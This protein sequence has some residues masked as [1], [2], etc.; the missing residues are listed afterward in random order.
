MYRDSLSENETLKAS[1]QSLEKS[2]AQKKRSFQALKPV[3]LARLSSM[4]GQISN[5]SH[6]VLNLKDEVKMG[7]SEGRRNLNRLKNL[8]QQQDGQL[9]LLTS[10]LKEKSDELEKHKTMVTS[11][12]EALLISKGDCEDL[13][14]ALKEK[15][16][17]FALL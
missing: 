3:L 1:L 8:C 10:N 4:E 2:L 6:L 13:N 15:Q 12:N 16:R 14:R 11:L 9:E 5:F 7:L 17:S